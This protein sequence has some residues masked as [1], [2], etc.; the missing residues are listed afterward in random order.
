[1]TQVVRGGEAGGAIV[2]G[3]TVRKLRSYYVTRLRQSGRTARAGPCG[4]VARLRLWGAWGRF[5]MTSLPGL[6]GTGRGRPR[7]SCPWRRS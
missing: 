4:V 3:K 6:V 1:M 5:S 2:H 7:P